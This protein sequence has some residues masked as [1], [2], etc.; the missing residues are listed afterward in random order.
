[1]GESVDVGHG[2][3]TSAGH[4]LDSK[5]NGVSVDVGHGHG[6][7]TSAGGPLTLDIRGALCVLTV[8]DPIGQALTSGLHQAFG[9]PIFDGISFEPGTLQ[10]RN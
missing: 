8:P 1:M 4:L 7:V 6:Q 2:Q 10:S 9:G 5:P 3:V